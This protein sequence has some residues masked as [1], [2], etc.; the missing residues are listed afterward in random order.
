MGHVDLSTTRGREHQGN[1]LLL[2]GRVTLWTM[3]TISFWV[4]Q[5]VHKLRDFFHQ[6]RALGGKVWTSWTMWTT[7]FKSL[8][9]NIRPGE[10]TNYKS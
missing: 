8:A 10:Y 2:F 4:V 9:Y 3:W 7:P 1:S 6:L 5:T